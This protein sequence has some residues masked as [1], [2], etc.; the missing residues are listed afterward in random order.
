MSHRCIFVKPNGQRCKNRTL[1]TYYCYCHLKYE[2]G[3]WVK[4]SQIPDAGLGLVAEKEFARNNVVTPYEG[5]I[6]NHADPNNLYLLQIGQDRYLDASDPYSGPARY[7]NMCRVGDQ[8]RRYC[9]NNNAN[10]R[11]T[12]T[13]GRVTGAVIK[14]TKPIHKGQEIFTSYGRSYFRHS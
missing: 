2:K 13:R 11:L 5:P 4:K 1:K 9:R 12:K 14:A 10:L 7:S 6:V 3:L 8:R